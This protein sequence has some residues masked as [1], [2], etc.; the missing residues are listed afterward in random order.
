MKKPRPVPG[1][2]LCLSVDTL[3]CNQPLATEC[4]IHAKH[5][6][7]PKHLRQS[8]DFP[9]ASYAT[10]IHDFNGGKSHACRPEEKH[11]R[12]RGANRKRQHQVSGL[13]PMD[14]GKD[15]RNEGNRR[16][17]NLDIENELQ[18]WHAGI[19]VSHEGFMPRHERC[20]AHAPGCDQCLFQTKQSHETLLRGCRVNV[21]ITI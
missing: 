9:E 16:A 21:P 19:K 3:A 1:R 8:M 5:H 7:R 13:P 11:A 6:C 2:G 4:E 17:D 10:C 15:C 20:R 18:K 12:D 14:G